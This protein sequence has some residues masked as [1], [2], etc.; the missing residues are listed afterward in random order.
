[1]QNQNA[2][3]SSMATTALVAA[4]NLSKPSLDTLPPE[5]IGTI[6]FQL[7]HSIG[8]H[9]RQVNPA[10]IPVAIRNIKRLSLVNKN[11]RKIVNQSEVAEPAI[12]SLAQRFQ[13]S[14]LG[15]AAHLKGFGAEAWVKKHE[16][17]KVINSLFTQV[18]SEVE[19]E[20]IKRVLKRAYDEEGA[21]VVT[22]IGVSGL[23][24]KVDRD[25][26]SVEISADFTPFPEALK[27][28]WSQSTGSA[29]PRCIAGRKSEE[30]W[31]LFTKSMAV[32]FEQK[33]DNEILGALR[34]GGMKKKMTYDVFYKGS[35]RVLYYFWVHKDVRDE[36]IKRFGFEVDDDYF[37]KVDAADNAF[38]CRSLEKK[39]CNLDPETRFFKFYNQWNEA[40]SPKKDSRPLWWADSNNTYVLSAQE[41]A[42][43]Y[44]ND[45]S[46]EDMEDC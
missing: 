34:A 19:K 2:A 12:I 4:P 42:E 10:D 24:K 3:A 22:G 6:L 29:L 41:W 27:S 31:Y 5:I 28:G 39:I 25:K 18:F 26:E 1:M 40:H 33:S 14:T 15:A 46:L 13:L 7:N 23:S 36:F 44:K 38:K 35:G 17:G 21:T 8:T 9:G 45:A 37:Y 20:I 32:R 11:M 30:E 43:F 16:M